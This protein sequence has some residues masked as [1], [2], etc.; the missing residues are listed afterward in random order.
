L[1]YGKRIEGYQTASGKFPVFGTNGLI[2]WHH[3]PLCPDPGIIIGRKGAYRGVHYSDVPFY[4]IDT[5]FYLKPK[6]PYSSRWAFYTIHRYDINSMDSGSAIPSTSRD[7]F[8]NIEV[9]L[10]PLPLQ[11]KFD[12]V[13]GPIWEKQRLNLLE[14]DSLEQLRDLLL[15]RL[16]SGAIR[17]K[18]AKKSVEETL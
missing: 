16:L 14:S 1:E 11:K 6:V 7:D 4:V 12:E 15:P 5:A 9:V 18:G 8:Y 13:L 17:F 2:G 10:P 3:E